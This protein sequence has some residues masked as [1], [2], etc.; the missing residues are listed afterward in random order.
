[1]AQRIRFTPY[2]KPIV[3]EFDEDERVSEFMSYHSS[4]SLPI[5]RGGHPDDSMPIFLSNSEEEEVYRPRFGRASVISSRLLKISIL[6]ASVAA[7]A[8][9]ILS[10]ENPLA[11]FANAKASL[12]GTS[13]GQSAAIQ[14][15][16]I[17]MRT[18]EPVVPIRSLSADHAAPEIQSNTRA[19]LPASRGAP[20]RDEIAAA[21]KTARQ[22]QTEIAQPSAVAPVAVAPVAVAAAP[23]A[24]A[25]APVAVAPATVVPVAVAPAARRLAPDELAT[26]LKRAKSLIAV[27]DIAPARLLLER[28]A[29]TQEPSATL[30]LA[31]TYDPA[32]LGTQDMRSV[33]PDLAK[34]RDWYQKAAR[35]G[36]QDAQQ[37][38]SQMQN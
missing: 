25:V 22:G 11:L 35:F 23:A 37:R 36:S 8:A 3:E 14:S 15:A 30:L 24:V 38:L 33:T 18:P 20:T 28:A 31:Q 7:I 26:L 1:M 17:Q 12:I 6:A 9:A 34:A 10:V 13:A 5:K 2:D 16:T 4:S 19:L 21:F 27:G 29:D 32:V